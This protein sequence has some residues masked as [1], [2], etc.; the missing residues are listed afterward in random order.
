[1]INEN[2]YLTGNTIRLFAEFRDLDGQLVDIMFPKLTI[3]NS[4]YKNILEVNLNDD[5][6]ISTGKYF[7]DFKTSLE[8]K[9]IIYEFSGEL[10][11]TPTL[12]RNS[13]VT[14]FID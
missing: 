14:R 13:F 9:R 12:D 11:G 10:D 6:K 4:K 7:Y 1:M 2:V 3:Y 8:P 5:N